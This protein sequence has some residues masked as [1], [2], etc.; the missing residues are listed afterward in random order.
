MAVF[1]DQF[2]TTGHDSDLPV[3]SKF[4]YLLFLLHGEARQAVQG[5]AMTADHDN[6]ACQV[7]EDHLGQKERIIFTHVQ[8]LLQFTIPSKCSAFILWKLYHDL[9]IIGYRC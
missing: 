7:L 1:W 8:K 6:I 4:S 2:K 9:L 3:T 5:L